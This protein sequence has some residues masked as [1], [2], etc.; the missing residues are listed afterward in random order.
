MPPFTSKKTA[1]LLKNR[2]GQSKKFVLLATEN[3]TKSNWVPWELGIA[4]G[5]KGLANIAIFPTVEDE[6]Q[7]TWTKSEYL[8][9]YRRIIW[10]DLEGYEK[11]TWIVLDEEDNT[12]SPLR[13]WIHS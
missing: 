13:R 12:A 3:S 10:G 4:D 6:H 1:S 9:I 2:I 7:T 5:K 11:P 8:G